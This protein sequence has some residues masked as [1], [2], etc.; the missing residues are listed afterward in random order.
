MITFQQES[1]T[2]VWDE[3]MEL[4]E[5]HWQ[6][7]EMYRHGQGFNPDKMRY[8]DYEACKMYYHFTARTEQGKVVGTGG[9]YVMPSMHTQRLIAMEDTYYLH[10]DYRGR[11]TGPRFFQAMEDFLRNLGVV[12]VNLTTPLTNL[13]AERIVQYMGYKQVSKGWS[14]SLEPQNVRTLAS[15]TA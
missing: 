3:V 1:L 11:G 4:A 8:L 14:K 15:S 13:Q 7:T 5:M 9:V 6:E 10:P 12:E 2:K